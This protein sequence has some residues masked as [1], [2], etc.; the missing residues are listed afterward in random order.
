M[1]GGQRFLALDTGKLIVR[2]CCKELPMP[3]AVIDL[4][5]VLGCAERSHFVFTDRLG[6]AIGDYTP[7]IGEAGDSDE[8]KSVVNNFYSPV[9]QATSELAGV[10]LVEE[11]SADMI[12]GVDLSAI[13]YLFSKPTGVDMGGLQADPP[14]GNALFDGAVFDTALDDGLETYDF[15]EHIDKPKT[16]SPKIGMVVCNA[17]NRKQPQKYVP[18]MQGNKYQIALAQI[19]TPLGTSD[20][21][22]AL[23]KMSIKLMSKGIHQRVDIVGMVMAQVLLKAALKKWGKEAEESVGKEMKQ[24]HWQNTFKLMHWQ[25]VT[26]EHCKKVL[27]S[28]IF[29]ERKHNRILK[30]Q[31]VAGGN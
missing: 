21:S 30:V 23:A 25:S 26:A 22:M 20:A 15:N 10:S 17:R 13:I 9:P 3:L 16:A 5:N 4:V 28:H 14:Q 11:G 27:E 2:N 18:S 19:T 6:W 8:D 12:P 29:V 7:N 24:L 31:Q 1:S